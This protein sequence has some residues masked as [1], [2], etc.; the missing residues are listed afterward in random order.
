MYSTPCVTFAENR[1]LIVGGGGSGSYS[2]RVLIYDH[3]HRNFTH[4][5]T[6]PAAKE[7]G[8]VPWTL[9]DGSE[10][11]FCTGGVL[12][13]KKTSRNTYIFYKESERSEPKSE[14]KLP[15]SAE[16]FKKLVPL[17]G[18]LIYQQG[19]EF[20]EGE[21]SPVTNSMWHPVPAVPRGG[22]ALTMQFVTI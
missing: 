12:L 19:F 6:I 21:V 5:A 16:T 20:L 1:A 11:I 3:S 10:V 14:W 22:A 18:R 9:K 7:I 8:C 15:A 13:S 4:L 2:D 17:A